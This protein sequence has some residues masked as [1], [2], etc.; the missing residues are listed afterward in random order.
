MTQGSIEA[1]NN[2]VDASLTIAG[3]L[4]GDF[5]FGAD[6]DGHGSDRLVIV[7]D[8]SEG[9]SM[10]V[11]LNPTEQLS[12]QASFAA[13]TVDG[14]NQ[15]DA[16]IVA[17]VTG[18]F[19]DSVLSAEASYSQ[20]TGAVTVTAR[21]GMGHMATSAASATTMAQQWWMQSVGS[22]DRR[23]MQRLVGLE[24]SGVSVWAAVFQEEVS[25]A[26]RNDLQDVSFDQ[27][28]SG[29][30]TGIEWKGE[31]GGGTFSVG[32]MY[33]Y[34]NASANQNA[35]LA[36]A[37]GDAT[38]YGLNAGYRFGNGLYLNAAWQQMAMQIDLR[39]PGTFSQATGTSDAASDGFNIELGYAYQLQS[40]LGL[41]P[42]L[43][44]SSVTVDL[45]DF[46][47]GDSVYTLSGLSGKYSLLRAGLSVFKT[48]AT[49][50][51]FITPLL[52]VSY[53]DAMDGDSTL[54]SNGIRFS[55]D[56]SGS[57]YRAE[58]GLAGRYK[59]W[60]ITAR[61][62]LAEIA[63]SKSALSSNLSVRYRW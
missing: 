1:R 20:E 46:T 31:L 59:A 47:S 2:A 21:F 28:L 32:P 54:S 34:G 53:L 56:T 14:E 35:S 45:D 39:T 40:G 50:N 7:G 10:S 9:S 29:L 44:Y 51:G 57:G 55:N 15:A 25:I 38:A 49:K 23:D 42:Q 58:F 52:D 61:V 37:M 16:P 60:D 22:L 13:I 48:F 27:K 62:G 17:G 4:S 24:D 18:N 12:G 33:S 36:S 11:L 43:Q 5:A 26:P 8:V 3:N 63:S 19:A 41:A 30:Q 6:F